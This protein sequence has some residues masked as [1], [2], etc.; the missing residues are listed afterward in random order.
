MRWI[1]SRFGFDCRGTRL[2]TPALDHDPRHPVRTPGAATV[3]GLQWHVPTRLADGDAN[4]GITAR[5]G[6]SKITGP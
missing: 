6:S 4:I 1:L 3:H 2:C 5:T